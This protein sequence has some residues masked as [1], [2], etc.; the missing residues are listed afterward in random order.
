MSKIKLKKDQT[1]IWKV[2]DIER[3]GEINE[4]SVEHGKIEREKDSKTQRL[5]DSVIKGQVD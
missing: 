1:E 3:Q 4:G 5:E 2:R